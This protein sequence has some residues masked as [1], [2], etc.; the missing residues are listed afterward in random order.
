VVLAAVDA[1]LRWTAMQFSFGPDLAQVNY[2]LRLRLGEQ[3]RLMPLQKLSQRRAGDLGAVLSSSVEDGIAPF[4]SLSGVIIRI[5]VVPLVAIA[6]TFAID[7]RLAVAMIVLVVLAFPV[8]YWRR[9]GAGHGMHGMAKAHADTEADIIEY[10]QGLPVLRATS[11]TGKQ[12]VKLQAAFTNLREL[13]KK[14]SIKALW[15]SLTFSSLTEI[16]LMGLL[17][18]SVYL[19]LN[20]DVAVAPLAALLVIATR[21]SEPLSLFASL[22]VV[23]DFM[24]AGL[25][26]IDE[27][28]AVDPLKVHEAANLDETFD[29]RFDNVTFEYH[30]A[31]GNDNA[32]LRT[33]SFSLPQGSLTALVGPSGSGKT[34]ITRL[35]MRYDD[36]QSGSV[37]VGGVDI[38]NLQPDDLMKHISV[39]FQDVY[40]FNESILE[41]IR[42][43]DPDASDEEVKEAAKKANCHEFVSRLPDGYA[44]NVGDIGGSL[45]GGERQRISIARAI[46]KDAPIVI[47]DEPTAA[48]DTESEVAV[49][50]AID[51]LVKDRTVIVIAHRLSTIVGA[52]QILVLDKGELVE[53]GDHE[54]LLSGSGRYKAMWDAQQSTKSWH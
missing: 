27:L 1:S 13:Q 29:I 50:R 48:L 3:L 49:Q 46:L 37:E 12:A 9:K 42:M 20:G 17:G 15:P 31:A 2:D 47:L 28:L 52:N 14:G 41:N 6:A 19:V 5:I 4:G 33:C 23:F 53:Q 30:E 10:I 21:F 32:A 7:W 8:Y 35:I 40:L 39:V 54:T 11:Q 34:T 44:T 22:T 36:P 38:R 18:F 16:G 45:S 25:R 51:T 43:G 26:R 24:E